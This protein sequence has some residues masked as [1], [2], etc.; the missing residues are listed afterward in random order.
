MNASTPRRP[1]SEGDEPASTFE[2]M[3]GSSSPGSAPSA[4]GPAP[5]ANDAKPLRRRIADGWASLR[6]GVKWGAGVA[7][8]LAA[9]FAVLAAEARATR[10]PE[11]DRIEK[12]PEPRMWTNHAGGYYVCSHLGC[13][14]KANWTIPT[15]DCCGRCW[16]GRECLKAAQRDYDGP[17]GFA[18]R[19][20]DTWLNPG[21]CHICGEPPEAH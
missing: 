18:H 14:K 20:G 17:G 7:V 6:P 8:A 5:V 15:H 2:I 11:A 12:D 13:Q 3:D 19:F 4:S 9:H 21:I 1:D 10:P 16:P